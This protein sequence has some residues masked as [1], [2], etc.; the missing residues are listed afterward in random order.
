MPKK[1]AK[2]TGT[3]HWPRHHTTTNYQMT[4]DDM[5]A[6]RAKSGLTQKEM[7]ELL[8]I[9]CRSQIRYEMGDSTVPLAIG[10]LLA[11]L[12]YWKGHKT[13]K[14]TK[15]LVSAWRDAGRSY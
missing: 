11:K 8:G 12:G 1:K 14:K 2:L 10:H 3:K 5:R 4:P 13:K 15:S 9:H 7:G 6:A